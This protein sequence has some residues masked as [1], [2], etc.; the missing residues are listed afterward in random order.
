M[1]TPLVPPTPPATADAGDF[2]YPLGMPYT[3]TQWRQACDLLTLRAMLLAA[4]VTRCLLGIM[5]IGIV[6]GRSHGVGPAVLLL[7]GLGAA[8]ILHGVLMQALPHPGHLLFEGI[9][10][11]ILGAAIA[12]AP[13]VYA[14]LILATSY[15]GTWTISWSGP[16]G[17]FLS[18]F[19]ILAGFDTV[20]NGIHHL[21]TARRLAYLT[22]VAVPPE[23]LR[24]F[25]ALPHTH[26][27][28]DKLLLRPNPMGRHRFYHLR[29][30]EGY[31]F[32]AS[33]RLVEMRI[34][35]RDEVALLDPDAA[36][37]RCV[38][39]VLGEKRLKGRMSRADQ[40]RLRAWL[41]ARP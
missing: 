12:V 16:V 10:L 32:Y 24:A 19:C 27:A 14:G 20:T 37:F 34:F 22:G 2:E 4:T 35:R 1:T 3:L 40:D 23:L 39:L 21:R 36:P 33:R 17:I 30:R 38:T 15:G 6:L 18:L 13:A 25:R 8:I 7:V 28:D 41:E 11:C 9:V 31:L 5:L 26:P 29:L